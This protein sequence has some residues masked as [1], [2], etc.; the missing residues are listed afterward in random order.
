MGEAKRNRLRHPPFAANANMALTL[1]KIHAI[2]GLTEN[3][4]PLT[5]YRLTRLD[6]DMPCLE[7]L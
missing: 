2:L 7:G 5:A 4:P 3:P 1:P 6:R